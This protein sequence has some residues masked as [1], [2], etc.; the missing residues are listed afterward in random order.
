MEE[1]TAEVKICKYCS[2]KFNITNKDLA[3]YEKVSP[4]FN[5]KTCSIPTPTFCPTCRDQHRS[6]F[7]NHSKLYHRKCDFTGK[8]II[9]IFSP[10]KD[11]TVY[12]EKDW[13]SDAWDPLSYWIEYDSSLSF[14][15]QFWKLRKSVP[16]IGL[17]NA[18]NFNS[19]Y[20]NYCWWSKNCYLCFRADYDE[21][22]YFCHN[23]YYSKNSMDTLYSYSLENCYEVIDCKEC[24][25]VFHSSYSNNCSYSTYLYNCTDCH[26]CFCCTNL[27]NKSYCMFNEQ[28]TKDEYQK[29]MKDFELNRETNDT[30]IKEKR[31]EHILKYP[32]REFIGN[33]NENCVW[34]NLYNSKNAYQCYDSIDLEDSKYCIDIRWAKNCY[35]VIS[36]WNPAEYCY[37]S[38]GVWESAR[39]ILFS[40][41]CFDNTSS[42]IYCYFCAWAKNCFWCVA[43]HNHQEYC[44]LNKQYTKEEYEKIVPKII[45]DMQKNDEWWEFFPPSISPF[46]YNES[47]AQDY[48]PITKK[49]ALKRWYHWHEEDK[50]YSYHW[51]YYNPKEISEYNEKN[52]GKE[53]AQKNIDECINWIL[54]CEVSGKPFKIIIQELN[55]YIKHYLKIPKRCP[56]QRHLD[57]LKLRNTRK[58]FDRKCEKCEKEIQTTYSEERPEVIYCEEC[59]LSEVN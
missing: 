41:G 43:L 20:T 23:T 13:W 38:C 30:Y 26:N 32:R 36:W 55:F 54:K 48:F 12:N 2:T 5:W 49:E 17:N 11:L 29:R 27:S 14:F 57:R 33:N 3:F 15:E 46:G 10:D 53:I 40:F 42:M 45:E 8:Q 56:D 28:L 4:V 37:Q 6:M 58:L 59:F 9:S 44:I 51:N 21:D 34:N 25:Q 18:D 1:I 22:C 39:N 19:P 31:E 16:H 47:Y 7:F 35:D 50:S 24:F 52:V